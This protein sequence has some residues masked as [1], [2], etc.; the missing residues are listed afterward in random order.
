MVY[1]SPATARPVAA[2]C[3]TCLRPAFVAPGAHAPS[4]STAGRSMKKTLPG[5]AATT[6]LGVSLLIGCALLPAA[7][8]AAPDASLQPTDNSLSQSALSDPVHGRTSHIRHS[9]RSGRS[10]AAAPATTRSD[11]P[12]SLESQETA[13]PLPDGYKP[14]EDFDV[15]LAAHSDTV[16][17]SRPS[18]E[19]IGATE[20][21][22]VPRLASSTARQ[23]D[24]F[25]VPV[26]V[27]APVT[28]PYNASFTYENYGGQPGKGRDATG[29]WGAA[30]QP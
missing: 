9:A 7:A 14:V 6:A 16:L 10:G 27:V 13:P 30:G 24:I 4:M 15:T 2:R 22:Q 26:R 19:R 25:G 12:Q 8:H 18:R 11:A 17:A 5:I 23:F 20:A 21:Q 1:T 29:A 28:P 3:P